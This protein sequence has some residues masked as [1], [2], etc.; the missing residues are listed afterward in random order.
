MSVVVSRSRLRAFIC[1]STSM[2]TIRQN[3]L[4]SPPFHSLSLFPIK[5]AVRSGRRYRRR[6]APPL[7]AVLSRPSSSPSRARAGLRTPSAPACA[8][9][10]AR[11]FARAFDVL[12]NAIFVVARRLD[13]GID[14]RAHAVDPIAS[15][16]IASFTIAS[17]ELSFPI[18]G[19]WPN[20]DD[21]RFSRNPLTTAE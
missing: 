20:R 4:L 21:T 5:A 16:T 17:F 1:F 6:R 10:C 19:R 3:L 14:A 13:S 7:R 9:A 2:D 11:A 15:L 8:R 18:N 12:P